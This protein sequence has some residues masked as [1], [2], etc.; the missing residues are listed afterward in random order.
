MAELRFTQIT[1]APNYQ[2]N[3]CLVRILAGFASEMSPPASLGASAPHPSRCPQTL[4]AQHTR[5]HTR[6][7]G[8]HSKDKP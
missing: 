5:W 2:V 4:V 7:L 6:L 8:H 1:F 3:V